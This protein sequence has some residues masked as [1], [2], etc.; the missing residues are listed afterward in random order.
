MEE[1][2]MRNEIFKIEESDEMI[3]CLRRANELFKSEQVLLKCGDCLTYVFNTVSEA[4]MF[5]VYREKAIICKEENPREFKE[6]SFGNT[7]SIDLYLR[8]ETE[9]DN[10]YMIKTLRSYQYMKDR[11]EMLKESREIEEILKG[12]KDKF[13]NDL[14]EKAELLN[15]EFD[16]FRISTQ[17]IENRKKIK[18]MLDRYFGPNGWIDYWFT[19][20]TLSKNSVELTLHVLLNDESTIID[21]TSLKDVK[22]F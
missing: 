22:K 14:S 4:I 7:N 11:E 13:I 3:K 19:T 5:I 16:K 17:S 20:N 21:V 10:W 18:R 1:F 8:I 2:Q 9:E 15:L 6:A 12:S